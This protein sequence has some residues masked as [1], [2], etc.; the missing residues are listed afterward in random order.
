MGWLSNLVDDFNDNVLD[1]VLGIEG[2]IAQS[3]KSGIKGAEDWVLDDAI[4]LRDLDTRITDNILGWTDEAA[5]NRERQGQ[6][7]AIRNAQLA[8]DMPTMLAN[9]ALAARRKRMRSMSLMA[10]GSATGTSGGAPLSNVM[11][12]GLSRLGA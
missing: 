5:T 12:T 11:A 2:D 7:N 9:A 3:V 8:R 10:S 1:D 6:A 4:G